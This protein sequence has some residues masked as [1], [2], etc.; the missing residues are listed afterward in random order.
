MHSGPK[1][2]VY[3]SHLETA[4][5]Y[6]IFCRWKKEVLTL[7]RGPFETGL[8]SKISTPSFSSMSA[9]LKNFGF[10]RKTLNHPPGKTKPS[11]SGS[12]IP[13]CQIPAVSHTQASWP[14]A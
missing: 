11:H 6:N 4:E 3:Q 13:V 14:F 10:Q 5:R 7:H 1:A 12:S 2:I 8:V 9:Y